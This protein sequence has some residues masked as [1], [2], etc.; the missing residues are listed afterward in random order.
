MQ[1]DRRDDQPGDDGSAVH[2][3]EPERVPAEEA[4]QTSAMTWKVRDQRPGHGPA[5]SSAARAS[6]AEP[7]AIEQRDRAAREHGCGAARSRRSAEQH[8]ER[9]RGARTRSTRSD[10]QLVGSARTAVAAPRAS[11]ASSRPATGGRPARRAS[12]RGRALP[13]RSR[14]GAHA[15][16]APGRRS[17]RAPACRGRHRTTRRR[18]AVPRPTRGG[19]PPDSRP[20]RRRRTPRPPWRRTGS[21]A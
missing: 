20:R 18:R 8:R 21:R 19:R 10:S 14:A 4:H 3:V 2:G 13:A 6:S 5:E 11:S 16:P 17:A 1:G 12:T 9:G 7:G 15:P